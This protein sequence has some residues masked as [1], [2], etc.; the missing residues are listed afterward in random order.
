MEKGSSNV[1]S[2][3]YKTLETLLSEVG[4]FAKTMIFIGYIISYPA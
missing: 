3:K 4:G 1:I 2:R